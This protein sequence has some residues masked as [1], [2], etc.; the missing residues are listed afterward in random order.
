MTNSDDIDHADMLRQAADPECQLCDGSGVFYGNVA[1]CGCVNSQ[2]HKRV[3]DATVE[4]AQRYK[5]LFHSMQDKVLDGQDEL[6]RRGQVIAR[7]RAVIDDLEKRLGIDQ[8][9]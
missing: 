7:Q 9:L 8:E 2:H 6:V 4:H 3:L 1:V 5:E